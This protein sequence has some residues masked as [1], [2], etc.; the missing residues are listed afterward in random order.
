M[1]RVL[2]DRV[3]VDLVGQVLEAD[4]EEVTVLLSDSDVD[5]MVAGTGSVK[6]AFTVVAVEWNDAP[7]RFESRTSRYLRLPPSGR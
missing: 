4:G 1:T 5:R 3:E 6:L 7:W 2:R